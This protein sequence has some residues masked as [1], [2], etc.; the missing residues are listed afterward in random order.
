MGFGGAMV[1][2]LDLD[3]FE[4]RCCRETFPLLRTINR[5]LGRL[6]ETGEPT[7]SDCTKPPPPV[8][9]PAPTYTTG[10]DSGIIIKKKC[11]QTFSFLT[12]NFKKINKLK[13]LQQYATN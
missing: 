7:G 11:M 10:V 8:T 5:V 12:I 6:S 2:T 9:P 1:Y 3:D 13:V 4:N